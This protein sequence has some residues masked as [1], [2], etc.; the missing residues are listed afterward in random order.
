[1]SHWLQNVIVGV[2]VGVSYLPVGVSVGVS[3]LPIGVSVGVSYCM[4]L[5]VSIVKCVR[6]KRHNCSCIMKTVSVITY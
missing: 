3:Y 1:M 4:L 6:P 5:S 2:S